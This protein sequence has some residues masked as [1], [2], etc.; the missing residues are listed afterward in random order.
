MNNF[1]RNLPS[2]LCNKNGKTY[3]FFS[4]MPNI[5]CQFFSMYVTDLKVDLR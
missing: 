1:V 3:C 2:N 4:Q 5:Q